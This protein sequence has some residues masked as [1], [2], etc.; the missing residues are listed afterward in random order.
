MTNQTAIGIREGC[1]DVK[2]HLTNEELQ[3][4]FRLRA[5]VFCR[6]LQW[7]G[8]R[9]VDT[10][11][12]AIDDDTVHL[13]ASSKG[14]GALA[15]VRLTPARAPWMLDHVFRDILPV[16]IGFH[17]R[18]QGMDASRLAVAK[19]ARHARLDNGARISDLMYKAAYVFCRISGVRYL[20]IVTSG[21]VLR[22]MTAAGLPCFPLAPA[23]PMANGVLAIPTVIDWLAL[24][25]STSLYEWYDSV[26]LL[27]PCSLPSPL[28]DIHSRRRVSL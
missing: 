13:A 19:D 16:G 27:A 24:D 25:P 20:Y 26:T 5:D 17:E 3:Q 11:R 14:S 1:Y 22:H 15:T 12:D 9:D 18:Q 28:R 2:W 23:K 8:S 21:V 10:E 7:V 6:E 4:T